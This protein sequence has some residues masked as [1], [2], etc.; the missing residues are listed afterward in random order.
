MKSYSHRACSETSQSIS[1]AFQTLYIRPVGV[2]QEAFEHTILDYHISPGCNT[3]IICYQRVQAQL[4]EG[5]VLNGYFLAHNLLTYFI[6]QDARSLNLS[7]TAECWIQGELEYFAKRKGL[8]E[9]I[10]F[11]SLRFHHLFSVL[12]L[13]Y[14]TVYHL[15]VS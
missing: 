15:I 2:P 4:V 8:N 14:R 3:L 5:I 10:V 9:N 1:T 13:L 7:L 6:R 12:H 11:A